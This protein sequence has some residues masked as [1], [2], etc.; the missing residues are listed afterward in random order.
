VENRERLRNL[1]LIRAGDV[2][3]ERLLRQG[4]GWFQIPCLGHEA[5][6]AIAW[7]LEADDLL[8][9]YYRDRALM[10]GRGISPLEIARDQLATAKSSSG[11]RTMP[12]HGSYRRLGVFPPIGPTGSQC[13]PAVGA[14]WGIK[15]SGARNIVLCTI[16]DA[17]T[18][19]GEFYEAVAFAVQERLPVVFVVE[20]NGFGIS[21]P[22]LK[23]LPFRLGIFSE[24][25]QQR[26]KGQLVDAVDK[27]SRIAIAKAR[28]GD[29]P[30]IL[31]VELD[32]LASHTHSDDQRVYRSADDIAQLKSRDPVELYA[33]SVLEREHISQVE[34]DDLRRETSEVVDEAYRVAE[35]DPAPDPASASTH[36]FGPAIP[37]GVAAPFQ[38]GGRSVT[39]VNA[40]NSCLR[41]AL[42]R[43]P[44]VVL[45]G[46][47]IEDPKG[48]VF[49]FTKGLSTR[50]PSR[51]FNSPLAEATIVG[52]AVG[53]AATGYR[54]IFELQF[55]DYLAPGF[56]QLLN[57]AATLRWRSNGEW[58]CPAVFYAPYGAYLPAG[59][60]WHSQSNEGFW[61][62]IP[63]IRVAVP[64]T[65]EDLVGLCW[66]ALHEQ[67]PTLLLIP[68]HMMRIRHDLTTAR[69]IGFGQARVVRAGADVTVVAWGNCVEIALQAA[70]ELARHCSVEVIDLISVAPCD[71]ATIDAS[72]A[73]TGRLV[74]VNEDSRTG[75]FG[76][77]II[78]EMVASQER[79]NRLLSPPALV[80]REDVHIAFNPALEYAVLPDVAKVKSAL[81]EALQ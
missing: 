69:S 80:A 40:L 57:Q 7:A 52:T 59:G 81:L 25:L 17:S 74:V 45:F 54:P 47:D 8:F 12:L 70:D 28:R 6:A 38:L 76:Q 13:L 2:R 79:F 53:L 19:Q 27:A 73:K 58:N 43:I 14:A 49:G 72:L 3:E 55:I 4:V 63:G 65:P 33:K 9:L 44:N 42:D 29:G 51:V 15:L 24:S 20:D 62:H 23:Q 10:Q 46:E 35:N 18:R 64:S 39:M 71:W 50:Y 32:R 77:T 34:L 60:T 75:C 21:T 30:T 26:V 16:G 5:L 67:D 48:G 1:L 31:W 11:G 22:T 36:L 37:A 66:T 68:K 61:T 41:E 56:N 78:S